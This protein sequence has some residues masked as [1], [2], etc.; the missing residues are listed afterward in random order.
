MRV[1]TMASLGP[2][3][4]MQSMSCSLMQPCRGTG[5]GGA[6]TAPGALS[7]GR[8]GGPACSGGGGTL[9]PLN[10]KA[11][12]A[13]L[14]RL[15]GLLHGQLVKASTAQRGREGRW[16]RGCQE[17]WQWQVPPRGGARPG[18]WKLAEGLPT[19]GAS[20]TGSGGASKGHWRCQGATPP[21]PPRTHHLVHRCHVL[22]QLLEGR[23]VMLGTPHSDA[24]LGKEGG[25][26]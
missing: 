25:A 21:A 14:R 5:S 1:A 22:D 4:G 19:G 12:P 9:K 17:H 13:V 16:Q 6:A 10:P 7:P 26:F 8:C 24:H 2:P 11:P 15:Q 20:C 18:H 23:G 3:R